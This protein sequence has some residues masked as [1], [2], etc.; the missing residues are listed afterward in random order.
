MLNSS[1]TS[2]VASPGH[3]LGQMVGLILQHTLK[4]ELQKVA[5]ARGLYCDCQGTRPGVR[6][7]TKVPTHTM[8]MDDVQFT[9]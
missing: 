4:S 7:G 8:S 3:K 5:V 9:E 2:D 6:E 1:T